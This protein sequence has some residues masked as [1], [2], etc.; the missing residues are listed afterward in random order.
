MARRAAAGSPIKCPVCGK[1]VEVC[2]GQRLAGHLI[3]GGEFCSGSFVS[4]EVAKRLTR[5]RG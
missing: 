1:R 5:K 2:S 4:Y 3:E